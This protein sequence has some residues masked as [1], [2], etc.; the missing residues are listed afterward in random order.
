MRPSR[1]R[2]SVTIASASGVATIVAGGIAVVANSV[3]I[4]TAGVVRIHT[5][6]YL[7]GE[8]GVVRTAN[9]IGRSI[10]RV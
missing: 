8:V 10:A 5:R 6:I 9:G 7:V 3:A 4:T 2:R 1:C